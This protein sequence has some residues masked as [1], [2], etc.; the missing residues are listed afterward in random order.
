MASTA[1]PDA[2]SGTEDSGM[3][4]AAAAAA[5]AAWG[6]AMLLWPTRGMPLAGT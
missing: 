4:G 3:P 6:P 1:A 5:A 2:S